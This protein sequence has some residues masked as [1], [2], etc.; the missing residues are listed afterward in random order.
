MATARACTYPSS[1]ASTCLGRI[2]NATHPSQSSSCGSVH[3][4]FAGNVHASVRASGMEKESSCP[5]ADATFSLLVGGDC[6]IRHWSV[7]QNRNQRWVGPDG[8]ALAS[9][10]QSPVSALKAG[11]PEEKIWSFALKQQTCSRLQPTLWDSAVPNAPQWS[12]HRSS[13]RFQN[14]CKK[15]KDEVSGEHSL[16]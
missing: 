13:S 10:Q 11:N 6:S 14:S 3:P 2:C 7:Y 16:L 5:T 15:C 8:S 1:N 4:H 12:Q 9:I